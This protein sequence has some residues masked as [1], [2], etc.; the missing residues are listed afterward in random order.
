MSIVHHVVLVEWNAGTTDEALSA[1]RAAARACVTG[2]PGIVDLT[3][4]PSVSPEGLERGHDWGLLIAFE[5]AA[6]RDAYLPHPVHRVLADLIGA[7]AANV[8]VFDLAAP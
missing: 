5:D 3:E 1:V 4:G 6:A 7:N 2:I 8:V